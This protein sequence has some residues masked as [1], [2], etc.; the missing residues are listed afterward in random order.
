[1]G[2]PKVSVVLAVY[3]GSAYVEQAIQSILAQT[4]TEF[5]L[6]IV[7]D[8]STDDTKQR[9]GSFRDE[10][11]L[12]I[13]NVRNE[14]LAASLNRGVQM[15]HGEYIARQD[16]DDL[17]HPSRF[18]GQVA[19]LDAHPE[20]GVVGTTARWI[21]ELGNTL[22][23]WPRLCS[24]ADLQENMLRTCFLIHGST[25]VRREALLDVGGYGEQMRTG[26]DYDLWLRLSETWDLA[27]LPEVLYV[28]RQHAGM[29]SV[30]HGPQQLRNVTLS[31][32]Q[33]IQRRVAYASLALGLHRERVPQ[34]L[35]TMGREQLAQ[36]YLWWSA[37][38]RE[39]SRQKAAFFV[40]VAL[41]FKP[42]YPPL[43]QYMEGIFRRKLQ[44][45]VER[46][47]RCARSVSPP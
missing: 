28:Y 21:D 15:A 7:N 44:S 4:F 27:C 13:E 29:A 24:N 5:E 39:F 43:W 20:I 47:S 3:N 42:N 18:A 41:A 16:A 11:I 38:V 12:V 36:R 8:A 6:L 14:G 46:L 10:R 17:S 40:L 45:S 23:E 30:K 22:Q 2:S 9:I 1:V 37:G 26:Q 35:A 19:F 25:M 33:A 31:L 34:R 32:D